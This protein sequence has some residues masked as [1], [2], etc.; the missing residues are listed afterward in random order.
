LRWHRDRLQE[1]VALRTAELSQA[2]ESLRQQHEL[3][4]V[5]L[6]RL[7]LALASSRMATFDW[8]IVRNKR[9]WS[10]G[11]HSLLGTKPETFTGTAEE[12]FRILHPEDRGTVAAA[13]DRGIETTDLYETEYRAIWPD[14]SIHHIAARGKFH[15]D[16]EG[17]AVLMTGVCWD[18]T[19]KK[20]AEEALRE[21][22][23]QLQ[24]RA[25]DLENTVAARTARLRET[26]GELEH[27]SYAIVHD[28][29]A[30]LRAMQG[31]ATLTEEEC[32]GCE[33][34][35]SKEYFRR[36]KIASSRMDQLI[37]DSLSYSQAVRQEFRLE[38]VN[39][40]QLIND[41][42]E[43]YPNLQPDK[44]D[45]RIAHDLPRVLGNAAALTQCFSNLLGNAVKFAKSGT[46]PQITVRGE[47]LAPA[48]QMVRIWV[49]DNGIGIPK[50]SLQRIFGMFQRAATDREGTGIGLAIVRKV[51]ERMG[52]RVGVES[53][54]GQGSQ[55]WVELQRA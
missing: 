12:F 27:F 31:F 41:L 25:R 45:I 11:V 2:N 38:A 28:M 23:T 54:P 48:S 20:H 49:Q 6:D 3:L 18:I 55:F 40:L 47:I 21:A 46:K 29:R 30:P 32:A 1:A 7:E 5:A 26:I 42:V 19:E 50:D 34:P 14:G 53:E 51:V 39:L 9:I 33:R 15:R 4:R 22:Q 8:D 16:N 24:A 37:A 17:R 52:G 10:G 36:I 43:T 44:T 13:L 35:L